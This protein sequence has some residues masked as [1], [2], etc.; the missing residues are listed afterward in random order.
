[1]WY[2]YKGSTVILFWQSTKHVG[3]SLSPNYELHTLMEMNVTHD[4]VREEYVSSGIAQLVLRI[5][6]FRDMY[7]LL[8]VGTGDAALVPWGV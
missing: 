2:L 5:V 7:Y 6:M 3:K 8:M 4:E 1:M